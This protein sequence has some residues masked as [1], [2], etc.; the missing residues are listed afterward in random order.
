MAL[1]VE[2]NPSD[3]LV[4]NRVVAVRPS[5][6]TAKYV[7]GSGNP[8][9]NILINP[10]LPAGVDR[11]RLKAAGPGLQNV[12]EWS[13]ADDAVVAADETAKRDAAIVALKEGLKAKFEEEEREDM[14][15]L[16]ALALTIL[17]AINDTRSGG[18]S[19][20]T[21]AQLKAAFDQ[22]LDDLK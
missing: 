20:I 11:S 14:L 22:K 9:P 4:P 17:D 12:V 3:P 18:T 15:G 19:T 6:D 8:L 1:I 21:R 5:A 10:T 13:A 2:Y 16:K 7:D